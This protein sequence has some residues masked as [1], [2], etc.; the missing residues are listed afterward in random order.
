[1]YIAQTNEGFVITA[2]VTASAYEP[3]LVDSMSHVLLVLLSSLS[4]AQCLAMV[5]CICS[6]QLTEETFLMII[7]LGTNL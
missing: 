1:M 7:G 2:P 4:S 5:L 6:Y 3:C